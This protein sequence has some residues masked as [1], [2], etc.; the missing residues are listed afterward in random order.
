LASSSLDRVFLTDI[1]RTRRWV[2]VFGDQRWAAVMTEDAVGTVAR[3]LIDGL[4]RLV[5]EQ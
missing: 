3:E 1:T 2:R 5:D 4:D